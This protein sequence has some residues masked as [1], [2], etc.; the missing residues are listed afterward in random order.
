MNEPR[1]FPIKPM[2]KSPAQPGHELLDA[3]R[4]LHDAN[5]PPLTEED[6]TEEIRAARAARSAGPSDGDHASFSRS[7]AALRKL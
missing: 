2:A 5:V 6:V 3:M 4:R 1:Q 7:T